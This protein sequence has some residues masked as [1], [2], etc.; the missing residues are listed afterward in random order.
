MTARQLLAL[1]QHKRHVRGSSDPCDIRSIPAATFFGL[2]VVVEPPSDDVMEL[3]IRVRQKERP[4]LFPRA[5]RVPYPLATFSDLQQVVK[6][7]SE[8]F[9]DPSKD[10]GSFHGQSVSFSSN[11]SVPA[12]LAAHGRSVEENRAPFH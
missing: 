9:I 5:V 10:H 3:L 1:L 6:P 11:I 4:R 12:E 2:T 8:H 7:S